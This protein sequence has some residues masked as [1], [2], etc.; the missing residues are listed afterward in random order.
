MVF[1]HLYKRA[2][3]RQRA[4]GR[5]D[6]M[7]S[8]KAALAARWTTDST[9]LY[10]TSTPCDGGP[11]SSSALNE[12]CLLACTH[13]CPASH[14]T[15]TLATACKWPLFPDLDVSDAQER[16]WCADCRCRACHLCRGWPGSRGA[17][18]HIN[19]RADHRSAHAMVVLVRGAAFRTERGRNNRSAAPASDPQTIAAHV[20]SLGSLRR[21]ILEPAAEDGWAVEVIIDVHTHTERLRALLEGGLRDSIASPGISLGAMRFQPLLGSQMKT[22]LANLEFVLHASRSSPSQWRAQ[23]RIPTRCPRAYR[24]ARK[25]SI[26]AC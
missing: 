26:L 12:S 22:L 3:E 10:T 18:H 4:V 20:E 21:H 15:S 25:A 5:C 13:P 8:V 17:S 6:A 9:A 19:A 1:L 24:C 14:N 23:L 16:P 7:S 11:S 2:A